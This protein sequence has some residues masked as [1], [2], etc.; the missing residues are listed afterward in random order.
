MN[1]VATI[2]TALIITFVDSRF[3]SSANFMLLNTSV[4]R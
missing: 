2:V 1:A 3:L 4:R